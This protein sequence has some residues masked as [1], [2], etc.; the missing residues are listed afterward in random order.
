MND[1]KMN[2]GTLRKREYIGGGI[3]FLLW[4]IGFPIAAVFLAYWLGFRED[5]LLRSV[6][7]HVIPLGA[8]ALV[9]AAVFWR[10]LREQLA[11]LR[12]C[13]SRIWKHLGLGLVVWYGLSYAVTLLLNTIVSASGLHFENANND[14][15]VDYL[16]VAPVPMLAATVLLAPFVEEC[17]LRG[18]VFCP[19]AKRSRVLAYAVS[20]LVFASLHLIAGIG[21]VSAPVLLLALLQYLPASFAL[22]W[23]YDR[24]GTLWASIFLHAAINLLA[25]LLNLFL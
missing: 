6:W 12:A 24:S 5:T 14:L 22:A 18:L 19:I 2:L 10:F 17:M 4:Q 11:R 9:V 1:T 21:T 16:R 25:S 15:A 23:V 13:G 7:L 3:A 20:M 8:T